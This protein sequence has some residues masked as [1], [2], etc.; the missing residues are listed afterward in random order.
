MRGKSKERLEMGEE[1]WLRHK[2]EI[3]RRKYAKYKKNNAEKYVNYNLNVKKRLIEYKGGKCVRCGYDKDYTSTYD[4][5][6]V[7]GKDFGI[8]SSS[9]S[10]ETGKKEADKCVLLCKT[11]HAEIHEEEHRAMRQATIEKLKRLD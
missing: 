8:G 10:F 5:H 1:K 2:K 9:C 4:F 6:H 7:G 3:A 11:C